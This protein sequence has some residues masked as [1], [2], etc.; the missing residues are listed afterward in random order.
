MLPYGSWNQNKISETHS[1]ENLGAASL[2]PVSTVH[3]GGKGAVFCDARTHA[4]LGGHRVTGT[5]LFSLTQESDETHGPG[6]GRGTRTL[7]VPAY[8]CASIWYPGKG[9]GRGQHLHHFKA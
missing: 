9:G 5:L 6:A 1:G 7:A 3:T 4:L 2:R 8:Q